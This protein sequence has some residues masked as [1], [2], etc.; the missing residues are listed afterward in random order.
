MKIDVYMS[1][2]C[3]CY[4]QLHEN[5]ERALEELHIEADTIYPMVSYDEAVS[6]GIKGSPS[7]WINGKDAFK[8][9]CSPGIT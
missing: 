1:E 5:V 3:G 7:V 9:Q 2:Y 6:R 4:Y 8:S